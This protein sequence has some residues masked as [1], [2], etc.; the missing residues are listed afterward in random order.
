MRERGVGAR[1]RFVF[2]APPSFEALEARLR[3]RGTETEEKI[4]ARRKRLREALL[5]VSNPRA[6]RGL[7]Q[8]RLANARE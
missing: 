3:G 2:I 7:W 1:L 4:Q 8:V 5:R 6:R